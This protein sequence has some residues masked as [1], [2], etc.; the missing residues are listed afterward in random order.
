MPP[1]STSSSFSAPP[2]L[3]LFSPKPQF[4]P[5][6]L[7]IRRGRSISAAPSIGVSTHQPHPRKN[8]NKKSG[9]RGR[10]EGG[11]GLSEEEDLVK[12]ILSKSDG[13]ERN[14][15]QPLVTRLNKYVKVIRTE[16]CFLLFEDLGRKDKWLQC[17]EVLTIK[18]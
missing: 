4:L 2:L 13:D 14:K 9:G 12:F 5:N 10:R 8:R 7:P 15:Q 11:V 1:T 16:H 6:T 18:S 17:L 3:P